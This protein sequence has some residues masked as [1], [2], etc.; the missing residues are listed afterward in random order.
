MLR[1]T[2]ATL[3]EMPVQSPATIVVGPVAALD[4]VHGLVDALTESS[5]TIRQGPAEG[6]R[7]AP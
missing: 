4:V 5:L 1:C 6:K 3:G 2:L 7:V